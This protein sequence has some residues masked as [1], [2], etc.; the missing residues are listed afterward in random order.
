M[1]KCSLCSAHDRPELNGEKCTCSRQGEC[2]GHSED[3][4]SIEHFVKKDIRFGELTKHLQAKGWTSRGL[5][6]GKQAL[7]RLLCTP[8]IRSQA[9]ID[10]IDKYRRKL[11]EA[12][13]PQEQNMYHILCG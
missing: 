8:C 1:R 12:A 2:L 3:C 7:Q 6:Q 13:E 11:A 4:R 9:E 5:W 10:E